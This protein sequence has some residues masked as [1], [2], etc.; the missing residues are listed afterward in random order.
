MRCDQVRQYILDQTLGSQPIPSQ[1]L[2]HD[3]VQSCT[4]CHLFLVRLL[5][6]ETA[7]CRLP[8]YAAPAGLTRR[9]LAQA[10]AYR[11][12]EEDSFLPW[13][14]WLP[15]LSLLIGISWAYL[16]ILMNQS[17]SPTVPFSPSVRDLLFR[18]QE[19][20]TAHLPTITAVAISVAAGLLFMLLAVGLGLYM[21][22]T[23]PAT[24]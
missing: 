16:A 13:T 12:Q 14:L 23:R 7:L 4:E 10:V 2:L 18:I 3:H 15:L 24:S 6:V 21:G 1:G 17:G 9:I 5:E 19:W 22:R 8:L 20:I 11:H